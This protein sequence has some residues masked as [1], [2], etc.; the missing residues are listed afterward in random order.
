MMV[1]LA[2]MRWYPLVVLICISLMISHNKHPFMYLLTFCAFSLEKYLL[3][4]IASTFKL[5]YLFF[6]YWVTWVIYISWVLTP[7]QIHGFLIFLP[8]F[9]LSFHFVAVKKLISLIQSQLFISSFCCLCFKC[10]GALFLCF[11]PQEF[12]GF[13]SYI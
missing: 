9:R 2:D 5:D 7:Y 6:C 8:F 1:L 3:R 10:Q 13:M 11:S 12:Q 4:S